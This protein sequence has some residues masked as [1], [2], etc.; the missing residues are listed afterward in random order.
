ML[1]YNF[2]FKMDLS[3]AKTKDGNENKKE[4]TLFNIF[5]K[6]KI[7]MQ[8]DNENNFMFYRNE[9]F[10]SKVNRRKLLQ[11]SDY[12]RAITKICYRDHK[13]DAIEVNICKKLF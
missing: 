2:I 4:T 3:I 5:S 10:L 1:T 9:D 7:K 8:T 12:F 13:S 11:K 6:S